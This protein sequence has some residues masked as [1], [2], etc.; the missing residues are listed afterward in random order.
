MFFFLFKDMFTT[1]RHEAITTGGLSG[2]SRGIFLAIH[3]A[4]VAVMI[5]IVVI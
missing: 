1:S 3:H 4:L 2:E 5:M